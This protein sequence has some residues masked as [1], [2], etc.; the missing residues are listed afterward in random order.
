MSGLSLK[1]QNTYAH[2]CI[3]QTTSTALWF[4]LKPTPPIWMN[5]R[6]Y[7]LVAKSA[8]LCNR[9]Q[10]VLDSHLP[11]SGAELSKHG[12]AHVWNRLKQ[13]LSDA[14]EEFKMIIK[15]KGL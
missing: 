13:G 9:T 8:W 7:E 10:P 2:T 14:G 5:A 1:T 6:L 3:N 15:K 11:E 4:S 12:S